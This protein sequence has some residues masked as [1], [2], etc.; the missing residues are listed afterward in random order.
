MVPTQVDLK[1]VLVGQGIIDGLNAWS[2]FKNLVTHFVHGVLHAG[3]RV[4]RERLHGDITSLG[5]SFIDSLCLGFDLVDT[6]ENLPRPASV[7][8][9]AENPI[10]HIWQ[11]REVVANE[12]MELGASALQY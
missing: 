9:S 10:I 8:G 2:S 3:T 12:A 1:V 7:D 4:F 6:G 11:C 5:P